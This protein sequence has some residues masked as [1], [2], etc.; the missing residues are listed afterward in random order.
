[1]RPKGSS[2]RVLGSL[3]TYAAREKEHGH[4]G[5]ERDTVC[6]HE[7]KKQVIAIATASTAIA[8]FNSS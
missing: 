5:S 7:Y 1:M 4:D 8:R 2:V 3:F 6:E